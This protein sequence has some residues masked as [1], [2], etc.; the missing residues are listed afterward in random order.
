M[1]GPA[2]SGKTT[3]LRKLLELPNNIS[4]ACINNA[5]YGPGQC[6]IARIE[7][8]DHRDLR[9]CEIRRPF[10][11]QPDLYGA[12]VRTVIWV[13]DN[14]ISYTDTQLNEMYYQL[15]TLIGEAFTKPVN[16]LVLLN[17]EGKMTGKQWY[18]FLRL[19]AMKTC[20]WYR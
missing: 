2:N 17:K 3:I 16:L 7:T 1:A 19:S 18:D 11:W 20:M 14:S 12:T 15:H 5:P 9:I 10:I 8:N 13:I 4:S 6:N